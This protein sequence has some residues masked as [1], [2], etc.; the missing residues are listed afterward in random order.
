[1][2]TVFRIFLNDLKTFH[3]N[4]VVF[5]V[6]IG[7]AILP[8]L[9]SWFNIASNWDPYSA[10]SGLMFAV[11]SNDKGYNY[12][13]LTINAG[14][15]IVENLKANPKMGW[16]FVSEQ[17]AVDG[18]ECGRYYAAVVI[19]ESFSENLCSLTTGKFNQA[20]IDY[21]VNEKKNAIAPKITTTGVNTIIGEVKSA[22]VAAITNVIATTL[23]LTTEELGTDLQ[24]VVDKIVEHL[25]DAGNEIDTFNASVDVFNSTIDSLNELL[26]TNKELLPL[27]NEKMSG[28]DKVTEDINAVIQ[29]SRSASKAL[30]EAVSA[31]TAS[32]EELQKSVDES[33]KPALDE[34][35]KDANA[36]ADKLEKVTAINR[37][38][39][40]INN[41]LL[42]T[43]RNIE[44]RLGLKLTRITGLVE[45]SNERQQKQIEKI[46]NA[47]DVIRRTGALP[48]ELRTELLNTL[49]EGKTEISGIVTE[50][51]TV[52]TDLNKVVD[53]IYDALV[54]VSDLGKELNKQAPVF[55]K[56]LDSTMTALNEMKTTFGKVKV[57]M[58]RTKEDI[59]NLIKRVKDVKDESKALDFVRG[60]IS[61]PED[62]SR[63]ISDPVSTNTHRIYPI[64]N[65]GSAM[66]PFY[67][68]LGIWVGGIVL[69]AVMRAELTKRQ[70]LQLK[71]ANQTQLYF[72]RYLIF[73]V[74][75]QLQALIIALGDLYF[76]RIQ[77]N[78][79]FLFVIGCLISAFVYSLIIYS[80]TIAFSVIGKALAVIILVLQVAGSGGT[81]PV[82]VLP[83][84]FQAIVPYLPFR[85]GI[86]VLREAVAGPDVSV[87]WRNVLY[88][89]IF[90][91]FALLIGLLLRRPCMKLMAFFDKRTHQ[92]EL[93]I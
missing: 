31:V 48:N 2:K 71:K 41:F 18:V 57:L 72:G 23:N 78:D 39:I 61:K 53:D 37:K 89:L 84:P 85:Y 30:S 82:E 44:N 45:R 25:N 12:K 43:F 81:F 50:Y 75:S 26:K 22:Y 93:I 54:N 28:S 49:A 42:T 35:E 16:D 46:E 60:I 88:L 34:V 65:Y 27:L 14:N 92:S 15:E 70:L 24:D 6:V 10:T 69:C 38:I 91:P 59:N 90:V 5:A 64:E 52:K 1:M 33:V 63:F 13:S 56:T 76:L 29:S 80:L 19:P 62:L 4:I 47:A 87:Y 20:Q 86:D 7:I 55:E 3:R 83:A 73:F 36:A 8:A 66:T 21:Y 68:A 32:A 9:Y 11:C 74:I 79:P 58:N 17:E 67:T 40:S 51:D 77:C